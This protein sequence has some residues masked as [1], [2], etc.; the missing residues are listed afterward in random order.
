MAK[1]AKVTLGKDEI[2]CV[3]TTVWFYCSN[4]SY[5]ELR[6]SLDTLRLETDKQAGYHQNLAKQIREDLEAPTSNFIARQM[7]HKK[8]FQ[9]AIEKK[10]KTKQ[11]QEFHVN[12]A[13]EKYKSDCLRI[14]SYTAQSGLMQGKELEKIQIKLER[15]QQTV[16]ANER[17]FANF[18]K[19]LQ[20]TVTEWE[21]DWKAF[22][23]S[24]QDQEEERME[25]MKDTM[26]AYANA[27]STVCVSDDEVSGPFFV[28]ARANIH[29]SPASTCELR[30]NKR[31][32]REIWKTLF[33]TMV[34]A[35]PYLIH[36]HSST[37]TTPKPFHQARRALPLDLLSSLV[38]LSDNYLLG[39]LPHPSKTNLLLI[40]RV[41]VLGVGG[42]RPTP[43]EMFNLQADL[44]P[45]A[46][47]VSVVR[48]RQTGTEVLLQMA[49]VLLNN[50]TG[51]SLRSLLSSHLVIHMLILSIQPPKRCSKLG[52]KRI[53]SIR[54]KTHSRQVTAGTQ[55][56]QRRMVASATRMIPW[57]REWL[58]LIKLFPARVVTEEGIA[59]TVPHIHHRTL[60]VVKAASRGRIPLEML[61]RLL[62]QPVTL[63]LP[64]AIIVTLPRL[65]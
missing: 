14:N 25:F 7:H 29:A 39:N 45:K 17:D 52:T 61:C 62:R 23:D 59:R 54:P 32:R 24:C 36:L 12:Q 46:V 2:G 41:L 11:Q 49:L 3:P 58:S 53:K 8:T 43:L 65:L 33:G 30:S 4:R 51:A 10:F 26:W 6:N 63:Q 64:R 16:Q 22:C 34:Q 56:R 19:N 31:N 9:A 44:K 1:L 28:G 15:A 21:Q 38:H 35:M 60:E 57:P 55:R 48:H 42:E 5:R 13:Q 37:T 27:V 50:S 40:P 20:T 18:A 47:R